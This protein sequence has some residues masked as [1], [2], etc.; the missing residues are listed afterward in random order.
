MLKCMSERNFIIAAFAK[1]W[2]LRH[3]S[4]LWRVQ[5]RF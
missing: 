2:I 1:T 5:L 4:A 3:P